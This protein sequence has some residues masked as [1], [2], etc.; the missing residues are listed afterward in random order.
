[1]AIQ[2]NLLPDVKAQYIKSE[3]T[4]RTAIVISLIV[5]VA[6]FGLVALMASVVYGAQKL[7]LASSNKKIDQLSKELKGT[8]DIEKMLT[9]QSQL[10]SLDTLH[11]GKTVNSR[12]FTYL[13]QI[14]PSKVQI[15]EVII[16]QEAGTAIITGT[17]DSLESNNVF[18]DTLKY[19]KF[20][21]TGNDEQKQAFP[22]VV[23]TTFARDDKGATFKIDLKYDP[24]LF[25]TTSEAIEL[26]LRQ[27]VTTRTTQPNA[28]F[29]KPAEVNQ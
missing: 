6:S 5:I 24:E 13:A 11:N 1:M 19:T 25:S 28:L 9:V 8:K 16:D 3:R 29:N 2:L 20:K 22:E 17:S 23:L 26:V 4:R 15:S 12:L 10:G 7:A 27:G 21:T 14:V 18:V